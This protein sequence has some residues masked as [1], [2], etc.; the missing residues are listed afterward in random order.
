[1]KHVLFLLAILHIL[2]TGFR[3]DNTNIPLR[4][5][6]HTPNSAILL[7]REGLLPSTAQFSAK[8]LER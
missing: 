5:P 1:M 7:L 3:S 6:Y 8:T 2:W 4:G